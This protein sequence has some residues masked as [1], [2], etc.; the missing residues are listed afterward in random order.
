MSKKVRILYKQYETQRHICRVF[1]QTLTMAFSLCKANK[2]ID[3][4][5]YSDIKNNLANNKN[6]DLT[7]IKKFFY[8]S[9]QFTNYR[10][11]HDRGNLSFMLRS[12]EENHNSI[13]QLNK[14]YDSRAVVD[15]CQKMREIRETILG[16]LVYYRNYFSHDFSEIDDLAFDLA[17]I[18]NV[19]RLFNI[20]MVNKEDY[21]E[22]ERLI[23]NFKNLLEDLVNLSD[24]EMA[25]DTPP[26]ETV[27][28][29]QK[30]EKQNV[31]EPDI[32]KIIEQLKQDLTGIEDRILNKID[33]LGSKSV[34]KTDVPL[35]EKR[36]TKEVEP[37]PLQTE[38]I[39][40]EHEEADYNSEISS[41]ISMISPTVLRQKLN[42]ISASIKA[43]YSNEKSFGARDHL[44][45][46]ANILLILDSEP[47]SFDKFIELEGIRLRTNMSSKFVKEQIETYKGELDI[48]FSNVL[49]SDPF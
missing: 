10:G 19:L 16:S 22:N 6:S 1:H 27:P 3:E 34:M 48:L 15:F 23:E 21:Q 43:H 46:L 26:V 37:E 28:L 29:E 24:N 17:I 39:G 44:L 49:W 4:T 32:S 33:K 30:V 41:E 7:V 36:A 5:V 2:T 38:Q 14:K 35:E 47:D 8:N 45:Q 13:L 25:S 11:E 9:Y 40:Q 12:V 18:S 42:T 31:N 20:G